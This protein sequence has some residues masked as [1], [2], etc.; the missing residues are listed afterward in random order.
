MAHIIL[1]ETTTHKI[2]KMKIQRFQ[3]EELP[4]GILGRFGLTQEMLEDL[5]QKAIED[6]L[7]G[8]R[9]PVLPISVTDESGEEIHARTRFAFIRM[10]DN[11]VDVVF[12][13][14][15]KAGRLDRFTEE[16]RKALLEH[17]P[18]IAPVTTPEG[19]EIQAFHQI[20]QG[21]NQIIYVPTPVIGRNLEYAAN[22]MKLT[23]AELTCLQKGL[24]ITVMDGDDLYTI[25]IDLNEKTGVR[26]T[27]GD[28]KKWREE[29]RQGFGRY[30]FGLNGCWVADEEGNL[31]Y[32]P[33]ASYTE[34]LWEEMR[35]R[36]N[37]TL[38]H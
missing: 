2:I 24:P 10:D 5:P 32:V 26:L 17:R 30:N 6:I 4:Y 28:E 38:K 8:R 27:H 13:P 34:E 36:N 31:D 11:S 33:E 14:Q 22:E 16:E 19:R 23:N 18:V 29:Q 15:L 20:D 9:S 1:Q 7:D 35:K 25:G 21:T 12:Y 37:M 3:S